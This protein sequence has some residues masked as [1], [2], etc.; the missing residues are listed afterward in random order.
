MKLAHPII[1]HNDARSSV[2]IDFATLVALLRKEIKS[3]EGAQDPETVA[4]V[5]ALLATVRLNPKEWG[6]YTHFVGNRYTRTLVGMDS[7]F[8]VLLLSWERGQFSPIHSH[9]NSSC[10]VKVLDGK[11]QETIYDF[12][13]PN[14]GPLP[15]RS[16]AVFS[17]NQA[18]YIDDSYGIHKMGNP[19]ND[20]PAVSLHVYAPAYTACHIFDRIS[21]ERRLVS[22]GSI[23]SKDVAPNNL[24]ELTDVGDGDYAMLGN[25][26][27]I[28]LNTFIE[29]VS[30]E[31]DHKESGTQSI[32]ALLEKL[33]LSKDEW[34]RFVHFGETHYSRNL[35]L[36]HEKFSV[37][38]L[39][40]KEGQGT[41]L[42][43][44]GDDRHSWY[45][46]LAGKLEV[47]H[48]RDDERQRL[49][50]CGDSLRP[51]DLDI[52]S[53]EVV[54][55]N[56]PVVYEGP[57]D[58]WHTL[59]NPEG[60]NS[61]AVSIHVYS[62][63][64]MELKYECTNSGESK[65]IPVVHYGHK[66][67][68]MECVGSSWHGY[69]I[70]SNLASFKTLLDETFSKYL[71]DND[72]ALHENITNLM[73]QIQFNTEEWKAHAQLHP[74]HFTR[75]LL[76]QTERWMLILTCWDKDQGTPI[77]DHQGSYNWI[78]V[79]DGNLL[80]E[81]F[82]CLKTDCKESAA[83]LAADQLQ[84][85]PERKYEERCVQLIRSGVIPEDSVTFLNSSI[86]HRIRNISG[87]PA[88][89]L[90]LYSPP[91]VKAQAYDVVSG[92]TQLVFLPQL[93]DPGRGGSGGSDSYWH[94]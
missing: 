38:L 12:P 48:Y 24:P 35:L 86:I 58:R 30:M 28:S 41:P 77:H 69:D 4:R 26:D 14:K 92:D 7:K 27:K 94:I 20:K 47:T 46:V 3:G 50:M 73:S 11:L 62:P 1:P 15:L 75:V 65:K 79:L 10:W 31:V 54:D 67:S 17:P 44:H 9:A 85:T 18:T 43:R 59:G 56:H 51:Q 33:V 64:Y 21:G 13:G 37:M 83:K 22:L 93:S 23:Y 25:V 5:T 74:D 49:K 84:E 42:H 63:P 71:D 76:G 40:W 61:P 34:A 8:V 89:S 78:K 80:E 57:V 53:T 82:R 88:F 52:E 45:K 70:F 2:F 91:Y 16:E 29:R 72:P 90:H 66:F 6:Q 32:A 81:D 39:C 68:Q 55:E 87:K 60:S 19:C 36:L